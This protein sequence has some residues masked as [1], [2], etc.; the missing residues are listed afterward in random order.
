MTRE[1]ST[2]NGNFSNINAVYITCALYS[3]QNS[4]LV[5][6]PSMKAIVIQQHVQFESKLCRLNDA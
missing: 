4:V 1:I 6:K 3:L 5:S 2:M